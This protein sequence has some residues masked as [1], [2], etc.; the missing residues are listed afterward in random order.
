MQFRNIDVCRLKSFLF[1]SSG[2]HFVCQNGTV[3]EF[4]EIILNLGQHFKRSCFDSPFFCYS[5]HFF[6]HFSRGL[7]FFCI[8]YF[9]MLT[10][11]W[12][13]SEK[14]EKKFKKY[15][16]NS[17]AAGGDIWPILIRVLVILNTYTGL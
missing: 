4:G 12:V 13:W 10:C 2:S 5:G 16:L 15:F 14:K 11:S 8:G 7:I 9:L 1:F 3:W 17:F 6:T